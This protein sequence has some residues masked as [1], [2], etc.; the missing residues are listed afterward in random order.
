LKQYF[1]RRFVNGHRP[2]LVCKFTGYLLSGS[3]KGL[4]NLQDILYAKSQTGELP[5]VGIAT[6]ELLNV[7][8]GN[9][10]L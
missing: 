9:G 2:S 1:D 4:S 5:L 8:N 7:I 3:F 10:K 6:D